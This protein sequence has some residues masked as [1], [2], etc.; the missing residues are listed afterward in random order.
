MDQAP[1]WRAKGD[2]TDRN[3]TR[4]SR[5]LRVGSWRRP[6]TGPHR[7][8]KRK[9]C[10]PFISFRKTSP[11]RKRCPMSLA[12]RLARTGG[13]AGRP[14]LGFYLLALLAS[15]NEA[16]AKAEKIYLRGFG[17]F[18]LR[19]KKERQGRNPRAG[20][21]VRSLPGTWRCS[22]RARNVCR[23]TAIRSPSRAVPV[24]LKMTFTSSWSAP[25]SPFG[26]RLIRS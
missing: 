16:L 15:I 14:P 6:E 19:R 21:A 12:A 18:Q 8:S 22:S 26:S 23:P 2:E 20:E 5:T 1:L 13:R 4:R 17:S 10:L 25:V 7:F 11:S 24:P 9:A 3:V